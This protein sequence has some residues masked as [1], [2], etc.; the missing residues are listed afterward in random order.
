MFVSCNEKPVEKNSSET[1]SM[2]L[3]FFFFAGVLYKS[4]QLHTHK[5]N[6]ERFEE[7]KMELC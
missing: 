2:N 3:I 4:Y 7:I 6:Y 5:K 1:I